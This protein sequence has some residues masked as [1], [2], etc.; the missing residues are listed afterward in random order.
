MYTIKFEAPS[1]EGSEDPVEVREITVNTADD[2]KAFMEVCEV[3]NFWIFAIN[4]G[5]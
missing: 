5:V 4:G 1:R 3:A 2:V